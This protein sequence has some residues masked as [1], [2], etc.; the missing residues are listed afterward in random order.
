MYPTRCRTARRRSADPPC[1]SWPKTPRLP[2]CTVR[3]APT[4]VSRVHLSDP[5]G[6]VSSTILG[7]IH[8]NYI[9]FNDSGKQVRDV[10]HIDDL[11]D[12]IA[13][14]IAHV[15]RPQ[16]QMFNVGGGRQVSVSLLALTRL[17]REV[18]G[19]NIFIHPVAQGRPADI[20]VYLSDT[21][22]VRAAAR[23]VPPC[24]TCVRLSRTPTTGYSHT[25]RRSHRS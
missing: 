5:D 20:P 12:L 10:L 25:E 18:T 14:Q 13:L 3:K 21:G 15:E 24:A 2:S 6:P 23:L 19:T 22:R 17:C 1:S 4:S 11:G 8:V 7:L 16:G 9:E